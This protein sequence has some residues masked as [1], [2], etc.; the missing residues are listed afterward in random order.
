MD[1][2]WCDELERVA[3]ALP[4]A[5]WIRLIRNSSQHAHLNVVSNHFF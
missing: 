2:C 3:A 5:E 1:V 4:N